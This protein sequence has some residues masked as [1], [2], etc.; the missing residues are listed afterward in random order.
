MAA[1]PNRF[2]IT[3]ICVRA[4]FTAT[5]TLVLIAF[6][7]AI[8]TRSQRELGQLWVVA[9]QVLLIFLN[10]PLYIVRISLG[11]D[12]ALYVTSVMGQ[13]LFSGSLFL[14]WLVYADGMSSAG[15]ERLF[16]S[17]YLPKLLLVCSYVSLATWTFVL[18]G[19]VPDR[20]NLSDVRE[21]V[22]A[23]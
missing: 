15:R 21:V 12:H 4:F 6:S 23:A 16:C 10:D 17:F 14:F 22:M 18:N 9:L 11:G 2:S 3:Q 8:A 19:R 13:I 20:V 7:V 5:S 1:V